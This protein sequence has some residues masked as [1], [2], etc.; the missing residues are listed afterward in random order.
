MSTVVTPLKDKPLF[1]RCIV[2]TRPRAQAHKFVKLLEQQGAE[3]I[4]FPTIEIVPVASYARLDAALASLETYHWLIFTSVNGVKYFIDRLHMRQKDSTAL[5]GLKIGAIGPATAKAV[6]TLSLQISAMP[7]EY[8]AEALVAVLGDVTGQHILLPR[9]AEAREILPQALQALGAQ[10]DEIA[11]YQTVRPQATEAHDLRALLTAEKI[12]MLTFTS[13]STVRN[14][15]TVFAT[16]ELPQLLSKTR[17]GCIGPITAN[18]ARE[19]RMVVAVQSSVYTIPAFTE[20]I[21][22]YFQKMA[23]GH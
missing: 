1:G 19:Y 4:A 11:V 18:T 6:E 13:S 22:E 2:V 21:M 20:A 7:D 9:A 10:V 17:I 8:R 16:E 12:D 5:R 23:G 3:V 14:F 15:A